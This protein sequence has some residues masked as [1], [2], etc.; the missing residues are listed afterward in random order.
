MDRWWYR[1]VEA[2]SPTDVRELT[3]EFD[4]LGNEGWELIGWNY[5]CAWFKKK[6][7]AA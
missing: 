4:D 2:K 6:R 7:N 1:A 3:S 5:G